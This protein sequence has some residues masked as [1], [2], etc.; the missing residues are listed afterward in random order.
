M[1]FEEILKEPLPS[2]MIDDEL[3]VCEMP[4]RDISLAGKAGSCKL[5]MWGKEGKDIPHFHIKSK[6]KRFNVAICLD[7]PMY[8]K[9]GIYIDELNS[10]QRKKLQK[11]LETKTM[12]GNTLWEDFVNHWNDSEE[13]MKNK[14]LLDKM[15]DYTKMTESIIER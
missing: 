5:I 13:G 6:S 2:K 14:V 12:N 11:C 1:T 9:H 4:E 8:F 3:Y 10:R 7:K 15:P